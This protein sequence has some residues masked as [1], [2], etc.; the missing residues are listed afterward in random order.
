MPALL[1]FSSVAFKSQEKKVILSYC[2]SPFLTARPPELRFRG[3]RETTLIN[4][5]SRCR[6]WTW[7]GSEQWGFRLRTDYY[8]LSCCTMSPALRLLLVIQVTCKDAP[9][10]L[11]Q[12]ATTSKRLFFFPAS[13][14]LLF[15]DG[16]VCI[17]EVCRLC[18]G[19]Q[20]TQW[21]AK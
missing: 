16:Y 8:T 7:R 4:E 19:E 1:R 11:L 20:M 9:L 10:T 13:T 17:Q 2:V 14:E 21:N 12:Q 15:N 18:W 6:R 3:Q 5:G